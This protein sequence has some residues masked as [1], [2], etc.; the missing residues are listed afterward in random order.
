MRRSNELTGYAAQTEPGVASS[1]PS[2]PL[3]FARGTLL[4]GDPDTGGY[5][6][7]RDGLT[8]RA[9]SISQVRPAMHVGLRQA[10]AGVPGVTQYALIDTF[11]RVLNAVGC[12]VTITTT[13]GVITARTGGAATCPAAGTVV[14][15]FVD[16]P[17]T[18]VLARQR[19]VATVGRALPAAVATAACATFTGATVAAALNGYGPVYSVMASG[20][21]RIIG[22]TRIGLGAITCPVAPPPPAPA[23]TTINATIQRGVPLVAPGNA[24]AVLSG[25]LPLPVTVSDAEVR[26]LLAKNCPPVSYAPA[27]RAVAGVAGVGD[28]A[29]VLVPVLA[30]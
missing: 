9:T 12:P 5:S 18:P 1:G 7:R 6:P 30:R 22:F 14:G 8:V 17:G 20:A 10:A 19:A 28:Y 23:V 13:T 3:T 21:T 4:Y 29:P 2:I 27:C 25:G 15:R 16:D 24:T 11:V 26:E